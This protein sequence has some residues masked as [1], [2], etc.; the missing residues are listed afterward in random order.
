MSVPG[1][2]TLPELQRLVG[3]S[4]GEW[5]HVEFKKS[6]GELQAAMQTLCGF[7]NGSGGRV[8]LGVTD[9]GRIVG[10][11]VSDATFQEVANAIRK[12]EP[13]AR[14]TQTRVT[15]QDGREVLILQVEA[16]PDAPCTFDGRAYRRIGNTTSLMPREE[17]ARRLGARLT[18]Q[19]IWE[20]QD[21]GGYPVTELDMPE[22]DR[23]LRDAV[24]QGRLESEPGGADQALDRL[25]LRVDG[26][27]RRAAVVLFGKRLMP[28][29]PQC[30]LRMAR[31]RGTTKTEF[32]DQRQLHGHAFR[33]LEE[34]TTFLSRH[35]PVAGR[36]E[37]GKLERTDT[38]L[39]PPLAL[40]EALVNA[41]CHRDY[42]IPGGAV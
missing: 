4:K 28:D 14:V 31:F 42:T 26:R 18:A 15:V 38:P 12:L 36:I 35:I 39:Y 40:R 7:L 9:G 25:N 5:E 2:M 21:A 22:L 10:Q 19:A 8:F 16:D 1:D 13:P 17:Y 33:L 41:I 11:D 29:F 3:E 34:A 23:T 27:L 24:S 6:T 30:G 37:P 32:L 20:N